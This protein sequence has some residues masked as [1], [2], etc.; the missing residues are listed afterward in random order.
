MAGCCGDVA[1]NEARFERFEVSR[2][3]LDVGTSAE[4]VSALFDFLY[5]S[6]FSRSLGL[7]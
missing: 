6:D 2:S 5:F 1:A 7:Q 4:F 3:P